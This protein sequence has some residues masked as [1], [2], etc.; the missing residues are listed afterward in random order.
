MKTIVWFMSIMMSLITSNPQNST[1]D[2]DA[3]WKK[4][5]EFKEQGLPKS[6]LKEVELIYEAAKTENKSDHLVKAVKTKSELTIETDENGLKVVL[7]WMENEK[8]SLSSPASQI[9]AS[10][11]AEMYDQYFQSNRYEIAQRTATSDIDSLDFLSWGSEDFYRKIINLYSYSIRGENL[12]QPIMD[13]ATVLN[14]SE[15]ADKQ[16]RPTMYTLLWDRYMSYLIEN[17]SSVSLAL[18]DKYVL[19]DA[20][21]ISTAD[22]FMSL[23]LDAS[24]KDDPMYLIIGGYQK[25][26]A[27]AQKFSVRSLADYD[28]KRLSFFYENIVIENKDKLYEESLQK[29]ISIY[30]NDAYVTLMYQSLAELYYKNKMYDKAVLLCKKA[31]SLYPDSPGANA[32]KNT[33]EIIE[34]PEISLTTEQ[35]FSAKESPRFAIDYRNVSSVKIKIYTLKNEGFLPQDSD[36][37]SYYERLKTGSVLSYDKKWNLPVTQPFETQKLE[38]TLPQ[39]SLGKYLVE[40]TE[41]SKQSATPLVQYSVFHVSDIAYTAYKENQSMVY[42]VV[43][44]YSGKPVKNARVSLYTVESRNRNRNVSRNLVEE[45]STNE[46]GYAVFPVADNRRVQ[47]VVTSGKDKLDL[48]QDQYQYKDI[49]NENKYSFVEIFTDRGIYRP[50]QIIYFK[51]LAL[52]TDGK[53]SY[54]ILKNTSLDITLFDANYQEVSKISLTTNDFGSVTGSFALPAGGLTGQYSLNFHNKKGAS[55]QKSIRVEEYKRPDFEVLVDTFTQNYILNEDVKVS[56]MVKNYAGNVVDGASIQWKVVRGVRFI[57]YGWWRPMPSY[58]GNEQ[59][60]ATGNGISDSEGKY[61]FVFKAVPDVQL[62]AS[63]KPVYDY[64]IEIS[65]TDITGETQSAESRISIGYTGITVENNLGEQQ[66]L[67]DLQPVLIS[68]KNLSG[69]KQKGTGNI[70]IEK[71]QEPAKCISE[72]YWDSED[73]TFYVQESFEKKMILPELPVSRFDRWKVEKKIFEGSFSTENPFSEDVFRLAGVY[74]M[75]LTAKD[76]FGKEAQTVTYHIITDVEKGS[77]PKTKPLHIM[78][79]K[80][81]FEPGQ[82]IELDLGASCD[83]V[84]T[85]ILIEKEGKIIAKTNPSVKK[86]FHFSFPV[87]EKHRGGLQ[88]L[89]TYV[90]HNR[91]FTETLFLDVPY[92]N[93]ELDIRF[94]SF[95]DKIY[96]GEKESYSLVISGS[97]KEAVMAEI[98]MTMYDASLDVFES[99]QWRNSYYNQD[100]SRLYISGF[101]F[102]R[103]DGTY[104]HYDWNQVTYEGGTSYEYPS[105][106]GIQIYQYMYGPPVM[107]QR[108]YGQEE[109][110]SKSSAQAPE[111]TTV[112]DYDTYEERVVLTNGGNI[113]SSQEKP[114]SPPSIRKNL[115]ETVFFFPQIKTDDQGNVRV[116]FTMNEALT[117]WKLMTFAHSLEMQTGY[118]ERFVTTYKKVM[119]FPNAPRFV[120]TSDKMTLTSKVVN[121]EDTPLTAKI[122]CKLTDIVSGKDVTA[123]FIKTPVLSTTILSANASSLFEWEIVVPEDYF[124]SLAWT[125]WAETEGHSDGE[126]NIIPVLNNKILVTESL[127]LYVHGNQSKNFEFKTFKENVSKTKIDHK[128]TLE[129]SSHPVWYVIQSLPYLTEQGYECTDQIVNRYFA[130]A[131]SSKIARSNPKIYAVFD[132]WRSVEKD[133]LASKLFTNQ[134]LKS[135]LAEETPWVLQGLAE[136]EQKRNI[137]LLFESNTLK[138]ELD[139]TFKKLKERQ[140]SDGAFPWFVNGRADLYVTQNVV[141][142]LGQMIKSGA[143]SSDNAEVSELITKALAYI[144]AETNDYYKK[145]K[146]SLSS[147]KVPVP[148]HSLGFHYLYIRS[149]FPEITLPAENQEVYDYYFKKAKEEWL[150][151]N[152]YTQI[153]IGIIMQRKGDQTAQKIFKSFEERSFYKDELGK[154]W[155]VGNGYRWD[156]LPVERQSRMIEFYSESKA[157]AQTID[158]MKLWLLKNKQNNHWPTTK[159]TAAAIYGLLMEGE[160]GG[161]IKWVEEKEPVLIKLG[162][163]SVAFDQIQSGT[164]YVKKDWKQK[165]LDKSLGNVSVQNPNSSTSWGSVYYQ[166]FEDSDKIKAE[167]GN[168]LKVYKQFYVIKETAKGQIIEEVD[169]NSLLKPGDKLRVR[170]RIVSD[171]SMDYVHLKDS[172]PSGFE[173]S[174]TLSSHKYQGGLSYYENIKDLASHFF[175]SHL[176]KGDFIIEYDLKVVHKG[177]YSAGLATLQSMYA[178]EF[179]SHSKGIRIHV[180]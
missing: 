96:P 107:V 173:P 25:M 172:R 31:M 147:S 16:I 119:V 11:L 9:V 55:G 111:M 174:N 158:Q 74:K 47:V 18:N 177:T 103:A 64:R 142:N 66:D 49:D 157:P 65:A 135:A 162:G 164:G 166:Y 109:R 152:L 21:Y 153:L 148:V 84:F 144:D 44:R 75:T 3:A 10:Y 139:Q 26:L 168:P 67:K 140:M 73:R 90:Y 15:N 175:I 88:L 42:R 77:F 129:Y 87:E 82:T 1:F 98:L 118:D 123:E 50:G 165:D 138:N 59:V 132:R 85:Q 121:T 33:L 136:A 126:E 86:S 106:A 78:V 94:E 141:E 70:R 163:Q 36:N 120:R 6:A 95:R 30:E 117:R 130:N 83:V 4:V 79:N 28:H 81:S 37:Q 100:Y 151:Q 23:P 57:H 14:L 101:G 24:K 62:D 127:P 102:T 20:K 159:S 145:Q 5:A 137:A 154:Y 124:G 171:R 116:S 34:R 19:N 97:K 108:S 7:V 54:A 155:N 170:L 89:V 56:G 105:L 45:K 39:L 58:N 72:P 128:F 134:E 150:K 71:L 48:A 12:D 91:Y 38:G 161:L 179:S 40:I 17:K 52:S 114:K 63:E 51:A 69:V 122:Q 22:V 104:L 146:S 2:F 35:V 149:F 167:T 131:I 110:A 76:D 125:V 32:C 156:E 8:K 27:Y 178:P 53:S 43:N 92:T 61:D 46:Q 93:K 99:N 29:M 68:I 176:P 41:P 169:D 13:Y 113:E 112:F 80:K 115:N 60:I 133:A 180:R 143:L 160:G